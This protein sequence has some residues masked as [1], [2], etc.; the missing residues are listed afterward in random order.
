M[1]PMLS[2]AFLLRYYLY[3]D[4]YRISSVFY[5]VAIS[6]FAVTGWRTS[7]EESDRMENKRTALQSWLA[8]GRQNH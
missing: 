1:V 6:V 4:F 8:A 5:L 3:W 7:K 2:P